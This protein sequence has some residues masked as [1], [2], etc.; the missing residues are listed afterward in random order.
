MLSTADNTVN[1]YSRSDFK[2]LSAAVQCDIFQKH[3]LVDSPDAADIILFVGSTYH[4][5]RDVR[6][7]PFMRD[8]KQK[9]FLFHSDDF[10][11][12]FL[13]GVY[14]NITKRWYSQRRTRTGFYLR[15]FDSDFVSYIPSFAYC[16]YL[17]CFVGSTRTHSVRSRIL[18]LKHPR[19]YLRDTTAAVPAEERNK[20]FFMV[21]YG[22]NDN[23]DY[24]RILSRS[25]F[26][27]CPRGYAPSS[28]RL[29]ETMKAGRVPVIVSDQWVPPEG[30]AWENFSIRVRQKDIAQIPRI[31]EEHEPGAE[32]M[33]KLAR[34]TWEEWFSRETCF[35]RIVEWCLRIKQNESR[36][37]MDN[38]SSYLQLLRPF[39]IRN[40]LLPDIKKG[41]L[42]YLGGRRR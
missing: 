15:V 37:I 7:H 19:A 5:Y 26:V 1:Q 22:S 42:N 32:A 28:W 25:K 20:T 40:V 31:L 8:Y 27:I 12:P 14:V 3:S 35:H 23:A 30:P 29:F 38:V 16:E 39:F 41:T 33:G 6:C 10:V 18:S 21:D 4:D 13:P 36:P 24:G 34:E 9:C 11:I 2:R 17:F